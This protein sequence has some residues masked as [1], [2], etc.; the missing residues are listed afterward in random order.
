M[1][2]FAGHPISMATKLLINSSRSKR[3]SKVKT[4]QGAIDYIYHMQDLLEVTHATHYE[5]YRRQKLCS[6]V[7]HEVRVEKFN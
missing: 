2:I 3:V 6:M 1:A 4:L 5:D 7:E